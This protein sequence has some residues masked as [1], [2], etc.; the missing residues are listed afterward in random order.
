MNIEEKYT[1]ARQEFYN[2]KVREIEDFNLSW[3]IKL[4]EDRIKQ[5]KK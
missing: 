4:I 3:N 1:K 5:E 2:K